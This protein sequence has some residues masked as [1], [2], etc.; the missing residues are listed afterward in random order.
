M[1]IPYNLILRL[2]HFNSASGKPT[3]S[4][5]KHFLIFLSQFYCEFCVVS[6]YVVIKSMDRKQNFMRTRPSIKNKKKVGGNKSGINVSKF[7]VLIN[8]LPYI[9]CLDPFSFLF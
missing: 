4:A 8:K 1:A 2:K 3:F 6:P 9:S 7:R 5:P